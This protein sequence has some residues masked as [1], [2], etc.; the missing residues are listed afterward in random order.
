[1]GS[2]CTNSRTITSTQPRV[3]QTK[4]SLL[5]DSQ[6]EVILSKRPADYQSLLQQ[7]AS[8]F[9]IPSHFLVLKTY[10]QGREVC[11]CDEDSYQLG[12]A[13]CVN[14]KLEITAFFPSR[15]ALAYKSLEKSTTVFADRST[16]TPVERESWG[17]L[18]PVPIDVDV[19]SPRSMS[20][21]SRDSSMVL[22]KWEREPKTVQCMSGHLL[23]FDAA[24]EDTF[25][26]FEGTVDDGSRGVFLPTGNIIVTGG[27]RR[28]EQCVKLNVN[29]ASSR[30]A[31][32]MT[33]S[34]YSHASIWTQ[35]LVWVLGGMSDQVLTHCEAFDGE[36]WK[37]CADLN[38]PRVC[39]S[40]SSWSTKVYV[41]GGT[42]EASIEKYEG[43]CW[44]ELTVQLPYSLALVGVHQ[45]DAE[46][47]L[48]V[49]GLNLNDVF[50]VIK[51]NLSDGQR[52]RLP[53]L[54]IT[55]H[56]ASESVV[57]HDEVYFPGFLATYAFD[58]QT[59]IWRCLE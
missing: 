31:A 29:H 36:R 25:K 18:K 47:A 58:L 26:L 34:R 52:E 21:A 48:V 12:L 46:T 23:L 35:G 57:Y 7:A 50:G 49:G 14:F 20:Y 38:V 2:I 42:E 43:E 28:P 32:P 27:I 30:K 59:G 13:L 55:D 22:V 53:S 3:R 17:I 39:A 41:F 19:G 45:L 8:K 51:L 37:P 56:F 10:V 6:R 1:M 40:A 33:Q 16:G 44:V 4:V 54:P 9:N 5:T 11:I 15:Q 24:T